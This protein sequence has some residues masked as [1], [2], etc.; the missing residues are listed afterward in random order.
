MADPQPFLFETSFDPEDVRS[1]REAELRAARDRVEAETRIETLPPPPSFTADDIA[2]ARAAAYAEGE[3]AGAA[4]TAQSIETRLV[5][6]LAQIGPQLT[7]LIEDQRQSDAALAEQAIQVALTITRKLLPEL[8][9]RRGLGE[10]EAVIRTCL[11]D[12]IEEP[13]IVIRVSDGLLDIMRARLQGMVESIGFAGSVV[14][15]AEPSMGPADCRVEWADGGAERL[16][17]RLWQEI[18]QA[19]ARVLDYPT[20]AEPVEAP[21]GVTVTPP[22]FVVPGAGVAPATPQ[23]ALP[24]LDLSS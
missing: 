3:A 19:V 20:L 16:S 17:D 5:Q 21:A 8:S 14:L 6:A 13:R 24:A 4:T 18:D 12:M 23:A 22:A 15:L 11:Q 9:R 10:I 7:R 1:Q 2:I